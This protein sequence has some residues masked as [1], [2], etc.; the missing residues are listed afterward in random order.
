MVHRFGNMSN[1]AKG[2]TFRHVGAPHT[3]QI[4]YASLPFQRH[5]EDCTDSSSFAANPV[6]VKVGTPATL[7]YADEILLRENSAFFAAALKRDWREGQERTVELPEECPFAFNTWLNWINRRLLHLAP[8]PNQTRTEYAHMSRI[9]KA[10]IL[11]SVLLDAEFMDA[12]ADVLTVETC[13]RE[14]GKCI[15]P[16]GTLITLAYDKTPPSSKL[17]KFLVHRFANCGNV[18]ELVT[19]DVDSRFLVDLTKFL[20][21]ITRPAPHCHNV[22][23]ATAGCEFHEHKPGV[24]NC[25]RTKYHAPFIFSA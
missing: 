22:I 17:R 5:Q 1:Q 8:G 18:S 16:P 6:L 4:E 12:V 11:G 19:E 24:E 7:F 14:N 25:Y 10:Y 13:T 21:D 20:A 9:T 2:K 3:E 15:V 23:S